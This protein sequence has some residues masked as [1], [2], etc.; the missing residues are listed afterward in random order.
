ML[1]RILGIVWKIMPG[2]ARTLVART[3]QVKFTVSAAGVITNDA[4][5]VLLLNHFLRPISGWGVP[6]GFLSAGEQPEAAF[7]REIREETGLK[8]RN[9]ALYR[10]CTLKRHLEVIYTA[11]AIGDPKVRSGE[12][13][14]LA[15]FDIDEMPSEMSVD[16]QFLVRKA[17]GREDRK[18]AADLGTAP[19][20]DV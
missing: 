9:V 14:E 1:Y 11:R 19:A 18:G 13:I 3:A 10:V 16:Q 15:W 2:R 8:L 12:I 17:L 4:G 20:A 7:R 5:K 6:G